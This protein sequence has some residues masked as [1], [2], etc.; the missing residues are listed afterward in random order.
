V[1]IPVAVI[2][3][4]GF[5]G[6]E[7]TRLLLGH[8]RFELEYLTAE[9][10]VGQPL[11]DAHPN[12]WS[13]RD[14]R[15]EVADPDAIAGRCA[16]AFVAT[17]APVAAALV[18]QLLQRGLECVIDLSPAH[19]LRDEVVHH[20]WYPDAERDPAAAA[21]AVYGLPE[22]NREMLRSCR[23]IAS[24][25]CF[26][27]ATS[28]AL[29]PVGKLDG[30]ALSAVTVDAKS[31]STG[32]G[33]HPTASGMHARRTGVMSP[34]APTTHRHV[35]EVRQTLVDAGV[36]P[37]DAPLRLGMSAYAVDAV[38]GLLSC[39]YAFVDD[40]IDET[41]VRRAVYQTFK[42]ERFVRT[43][44]AQRGIAPLPDPRVLVGS[45]TCQVG[46]F[47]DADAQRL[48]LVAALDNMLKGGAGQA[49]Q[50]ANAR[51]GWDEADGLS[52]EGMYP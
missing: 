12:L 19:R 51:Y 42:G 27:T 16:V 34:Y 39:A 52:T 44:S 36:T 18:P 46:G 45:N 25:G 40:S 4:S 7:L 1:T 5:L 49:L 47:Y 21:V 8:P 9:S 38:R 17:S 3:A 41:Q 15:F 28:L 14:R 13:L 35:P 29:L 30:V 37:A 48:V 26:A 23:L 6:G 11:T 22:V 2:G 20:K 32:S 31:G 43:V 10:F 33:S 24:P 50:A